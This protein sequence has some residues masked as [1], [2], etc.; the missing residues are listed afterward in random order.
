M[1]ELDLISTRETILKKLN[2]LFDDK[3]VEAHFF[4]SIA[5]GNSDAYSDIDIWYIFKDEDFEKVYA[6]RLKYYEKLGEVINLCEPPQN[7]PAGGVHSALLIKSDEV[8]TVADIYLC[9]LSTAFI[10]EESKKLFGV[11]LPLGKTGFNSQKA[12][13]N[14]TY[15]IDFFIGFVFNTI[16]KI[17]RKKEN[18]LSD[19][20]R[21]YEALSKNYNIPIDSI[22]T[23][24]TDT[25]TLEIIIENV[26]KVATEKQSA[27]LKTILTFA[28]KIL[29]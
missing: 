5:L 25:E 8:I 4:G 20:L 10:T 13:V 14:E 18:P 6:S 7:A 26:K 19:V 28:Q 23:T 1:N 29:H 17:A 2:T 21:E 11:D 24:G 9:P 16:K 27:T 15:R 22:N 3:A 12:Q